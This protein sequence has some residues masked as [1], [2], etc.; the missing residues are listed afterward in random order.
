M[1]QV[2]DYHRN[3][4]YVPLHDQSGIIPIGRTELTIRHA[5][6]KL[7][8]FPLCDPQ[9]PTCG[10]TNHIDATSSGD[11]NAY[12]SLPAYDGLHARAFAVHNA[13]IDFREL[14]FGCQ[15]RRRTF[16]GTVYAFSE[17]RQ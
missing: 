5:Q 4:E 12:D 14:Y 17:P 9:L 16:Q 10:H 6:P 15:R 8:Q 7:A 1:W 3:G 2:H 13:V 11:Q